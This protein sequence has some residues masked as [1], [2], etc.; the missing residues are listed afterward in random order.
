MRSLVGDHA[1]QYSSTGS[2][3]TCRGSPAARSATQVSCA[4]EQQGYTSHWPDGDQSGAVKAYPSSA[5]TTVSTTRRAPVPSRPHDPDACR[6]RP[7]RGPDGEDQE[8]TDRLPG[9]VLGVD[10]EL[11]T[12]RASPV[13][14]R[15]H[16]QGVGQRARARP[17][18]GRGDGEGHMSRVRGPAD[19]TGG[20]VRPDLSVRHATGHVV[21]VAAVGVGD[22]HQERIGVD[23]PGHPTR[24]RAPSR[25]SLGHRATST[26]PTCMAGPTISG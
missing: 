23:A 1:G 21:V 4:P 9:R 22:P 3:A 15:D 20:R 7:R 17:P 5:E 18:F 12:G 14:G 11:E 8:V 19:A 26:G 16:D 2:G 13:R 24:R 10:A 6:V 25:R